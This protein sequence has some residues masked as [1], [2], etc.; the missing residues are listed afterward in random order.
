MSHSD[1]EHIADKI[2]K[3]LDLDKTEPGKH[4]P[5]VDMSMD[6]SGDKVCEEEGAASEAT[7][8]S[9]T[10]VIQETR[11]EGS[12]S[13]LPVPDKQSSTDESDDSFEQIDK[14]ELVNIS[15]VGHD[16]E[17]IPEDNSVS[18]QD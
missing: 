13:A 9:D 16:P 3:F 7:L 4:I 14:D 17:N 5:F 2:S 15:E 1:Q 12:T 8:A 6:P 11:A 18:G 10:K